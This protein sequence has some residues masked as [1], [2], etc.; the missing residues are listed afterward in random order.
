MF[1]IVFSRAAPRAT[2]LEFT[3]CPVLKQREHARNPRFH[4]S[5]TFDRARSTGRATAARPI[6]A[7]RRRQ[8][9]ALASCAEGEKPRYKVDTMSDLQCPAVVYLIARE[10]LGS[11]EL[12]AEFRGK[13]LSGVFVASSVGVDLDLARAT[14]LA[15]QAGRTLERLADASLRAGLVEAVNQ[16]SDLYRGETVAV[17]ADAQA[18]CSALVRKSAP[19]APVAVAIDSSGWLVQ[20]G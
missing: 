2:W 20:R 4:A 6:A 9:A 13:H 18:I 15:E 5:S 11:D 19:T 16:L 14:R 7:C 17:I 1:F 3:P 10:L 12:A 8:R